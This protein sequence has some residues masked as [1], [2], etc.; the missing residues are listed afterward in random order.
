LV[1]RINSITGG[2]YSNDPTV[3]ALQLCNEPRPGGN[4]AAIDRNVEAYYGWI[5][6]T[7]AF[8][9]SLDRNHLISLGHEGLMGA[10]N[11]RDVVMRA[12]Q[13]I[14]YLTAHIWPLNWSWVDGKNLSGTFDAGTA[15]VQTYIQAHIDMARELNKPLVFEEF[16][17]PR[18]GVAYDPGTPTMFKDRFYGLIYGAV[19][20]AIRNDTPCAGSNFWA[21]GGAGRALHP[22]H[23]MLRGE[24]SYV[25][26]PPHEPQGW[27]SVF[28]TDTSTQALIRAHADHLRTL[29]QG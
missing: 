11:R 14:D 7:A 1:T 16:G 8:I 28:N 22:D 19:E 27:Y 29:K 5:D 10:N 23:H 2:A 12:H 17:F 26:D 15:K 25:G 24:T 4:D 21:W 20:D 13:N 3:M 18:D 9:R 6:D